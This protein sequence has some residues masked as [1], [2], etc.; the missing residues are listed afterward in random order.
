MK[1][2]ILN[3]I[4]CISIVLCITGCKNKIKDNENETQ[5]NMEECC[6][7]C[8]CGDT[9]ELLKTTQTAWLLSKINNEGEYEF[10]KDAFINFHGTGKNKFAFFENDK[11]IKGEFTITENNKIILTPDNENN[12]KITC[13]L[14]EEKN[15]LAV[16]N[17]DNNFG[18][19]T[20]QKE[21]IIE[22]PNIIKDTISK[23]K[24]I[25]IKN[26][27]SITKEKEINELLIL[28]NNSKVWT[29]ATTLPSPLYE[30]ELF[31]ENDSIAKILYNPGNY[32]EIE[33]NGKNYNLTKLDEE[34]LNKILEKY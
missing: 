6:K 17:C 19:F 25:Q 20:L 5:N 30:L 11:Q 4:F 21:G 26:H 3:I 34:S 22:L 29:G 7:G 9:I 27:K 16:M 1:K 31:D 12:N 28:I 8:M 32:F 24:T 23:T 18:T 13:E 14:G 10:I 33:I 15:L 2:T